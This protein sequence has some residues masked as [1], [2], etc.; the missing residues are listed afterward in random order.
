MSG[1]HTPALLPPGVAGP[2]RVG[3][4]PAPQAG[5]PPQGPAFADVLAGRAGEVRFSGHALDRVRRRGID[6]GPDVLH[7]L[8][9]GVDRAAAKGSRDAVVLV[10]GTAFVVGVRART[11]LTAVDPAHMREQVF[12]NIDSAVIA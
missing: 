9:A 3:G 5:R 4:P 1:V 11:V 7:R 6:V 2:S 8:G 12:T 10:D